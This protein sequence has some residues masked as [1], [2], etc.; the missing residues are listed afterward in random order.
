MEYQ[1]KFSAYVVIPAYILF[2]KELSDKAKLLYGLI[3][4]MCNHK[5]Y[6]WATNAVF[7]RYLGAGST[8]TPE[9]LLK[10]LGNRGYIQILD[11][12]GG[13]GVTRK[14]YL[15]NFLQINLDKNVA[16]NLLANFSQANRDI[17]VL[18]SPDKNVAANPDKNVGENNINNNNTPYS[19]PKGGS[20]ALKRKVDGTVQLTPAQEDTFA[21]FWDAWPKKTDKQKSRERWVRLDPDEKLLQ[22]ILCAIERQKESRQWQDKQ[23]IPSPAKW[24]LN[25][26]WEDEADPPGENKAKNQEVQFL[27]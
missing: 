9:R 11:G 24:L 1:E 5:G 14:I 16:V 18:V 26:K 7:M 10:E 22:D 25:R 3:S 17:N 15:T 12:Q 23:F 27:E 4:S 20:K 21:M 6:C 8:K 19:P 2:D 13:R